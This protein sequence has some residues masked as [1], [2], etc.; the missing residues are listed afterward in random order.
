[1][2]T[3]E[4]KNAIE[5]SDG[6]LIEWDVSISM[7]DGLALKA[8]IFRPTTPGRYPVLMTYGP[9]GKGLAFQDGYKTCWDRMAEDHPDVVKGSSNKYQNWEVVD[10]EKWVP[11]DYVCIRVDSRGAGMSPGYMQ[12]WSP[13]EAIDFYDCIE[14]AGVQEWSNGKVG[15]NGISY[16]AMNQWQVASLQPPHLAAICPWEGAS[17]MYRDMSHHGGILSDFINNWYDMQVTTVQHGLG[18]RGPKSRVTGKPV[19]GEIELSDAELL[20]N[21][22]NFAGAALKH[23]MDDSYWRARMPDWSKV[24]VPIL[25]AA[26]WGG[27]GLHPRGN[28]EGFSRAAS[29]QK[30]LEVHGIEHWT[31]FYTDYGRELQLKFFDYF[32]HG[33]KNGWNRQPKVLLNIRHP[34]EKFVKRSEDQWPLKKTRWTRFYLQTD[35]ATLSPK[36][37][38]RSGKISYKGFSE[39]VTFML[40]PQPNDLEITGPSAV[41]LFLSSSTVDADI[42]AVLRVFTPDMKEVVFQGALD[43]HTPVGQG[44]LRASHRKLDAKLSKPHRPY[45][46]HDE[47]QPLTPHASVE[48]DIEIIPT[49]IVVPAGYRLALT[50]RGKDYVYPGPAGVLSNMKYPMT[51][52]GPFTHTDTKDRPARIFDGVNTLHIN[53]KKPSYIL[54]PVIPQS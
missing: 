19:C 37:P 32:L 45:H 41:K 24:T 6:M 53:P 23:A 18:Q 42:F 21:R 25:S 36:P 39:G 49:C 31:H 54:L 29:N 35:A 43:P 40:P 44:W 12:L 14:W 16:Y 5:V 17:D 1:M 33:K 38:L 3:L 46:T 27:Q 7:R 9:Y 2:K 48:M 34:G 13:Q 30:W 10:P 26:N 15:L 8:D 50:L 51:G 4:T 11:H 20:K 28:F 22:E 52:C 47:K